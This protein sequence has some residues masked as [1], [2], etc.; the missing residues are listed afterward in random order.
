MGTTRGAP[1]HEAGTR[2]HYSTAIEQS[3]ESEVRLS[4]LPFKQAGTEDERRARPLR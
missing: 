3:F 1:W 2:P 4:S